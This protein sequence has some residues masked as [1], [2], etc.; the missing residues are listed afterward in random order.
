MTIFVFSK[1]K[2]LSMQL[3]L[4]L[5]DCSSEF[6]LMAIFLSIISSRRSSLF[7]QEFQTLLASTHYPILNP[8]FVIAMDQPFAEIYISGLGLS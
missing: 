8:L 1:K 2:E 4:L 3:S 5:S 6:S 7:N